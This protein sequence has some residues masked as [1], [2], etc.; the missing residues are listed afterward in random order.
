MVEIKI[1][2]KV[3]LAQNGDKDAIRFLYELYYKDVYYVCY[4]YLKEENVSRD[5]TQ[6]TFIKEFEK[7]NTLEDAEKFSS[8][9]NTFLNSNV[10]CRR[11][12][13]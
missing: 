3:T 5:I 11:L 7:I 2:E 6:D 8:L 1:I 10:C 9:V 13:K 4:K 12:W